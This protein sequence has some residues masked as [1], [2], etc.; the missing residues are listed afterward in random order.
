MIVTIVTTEVII[1]PEE[2]EIIVITEDIIPEGIVGIDITDVIK[3]I[4]KQP[5]TFFRVSQ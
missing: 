4:Q 2:T 1:I 3:R 5:L